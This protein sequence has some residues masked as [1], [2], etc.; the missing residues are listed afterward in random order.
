MINLVTEE[1]KWSLIFC[2][3]LGVSFSWLLYRKDK[4]SEELSSF[5][6]R[7]LMALRFI[8][9]TLLSFLLLS[10]LLKTL[11][12]KAEKPIIIIAQDNSES[13]VVNK[14]STYYKNE[15]S[16]K[17]NTFIEELK[18]KYD[19][20]TVSF[21]DKVKD[22]IDYSYADKQ[23][24]YSGLLN[25]LGIRFANRNVG[26]LVVASD[27]LYNRGSSPV[28][29]LGDLSAPIY[30]IALGDTSV[31]KD[32]R[33][34]NVKFNKVVFLNSTFPIEVI[35]DARQCSG[36]GTTLT[37]EEDSVSVFSKSVT[38][39]G[40][41]FSQVIP[42][43]LDAKKKGMHHYRI[44]AS[45]I[46]GEV[47][48]A[49]NV[50]DIYIQVEESKRKIL[51][52]AASPH[53]DIAALKEA[54]ESNENY[55]AKVQMIDKFDSKLND[56][57]LIIL[58]QLPSFEHPASEV[59][60]EI[61]KNSSSVWYI[62]GSESNVRAF[63]ILSAPVTIG[64][65]L[66]KTNEIQPALNKI[67]SLFT[68]SD[69]AIKALQDF[70][71]LLA[72]FGDYK[73]SANGSSLLVQR[74]GSVSTNQPLLFLSSDNEVKTGVLCGE[75]LWRWRLNDYQLNENFN[76]FNEIISKT[77]QYLS[78][79]EIKSHFKVIAKNTFPENEPVVFDAEVYNDNY[80]LINTPDISITISNKEGKSFPFTFSKSERAY[81]LNAGF[82]APG[83]YHY[84]A[85]VRVG[86]KPYN[87]EGEFTISELQA[88]QTETVADHALLYS[89]AHKRGGELFYPSQLDSLSALLLSKEDIK[90][91]SYSQVKL[92][93]L[94]NLKWV[95][96]LLLAFISLEW[97]LR[98]R[99][100]MY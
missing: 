20:H 58:H 54:I 16:Q 95:F 43:Y 35:L 38:I 5:L 41:S 79:H 96:F 47:T 81:S 53:P 39:S 9:I 45:A 17:L 59:I 3:L 18:K 64:S 88:E 27:G 80:E 56:Y 42:V 83:S 73:T 11:T 48:T 74:I 40:S 44:S 28:F 14:D 87:N 98:K 60:N 82:F 63:N 13:I 85:T 93:D 49:N 29:S 97:F 33:I 68:L 30:T 77:V 2:V 8:Y 76:A 70:P 90:T 69:E 92:L 55:E 61:K 46:E 24:D 75:G 84:K 7:A 72:P 86:D 57:Q 32:L 4:T 36:A 99:N 66:N 10:P 22:G 31:K 78:T 26:A 62:L 89:W 67:F 91:V 21:G 50:K 23:T 51:I 71:P 34:E 65:E 100:G 37:V 52:V 19:V 25:S 15:Y 1:P 12:K 94:V 6:K